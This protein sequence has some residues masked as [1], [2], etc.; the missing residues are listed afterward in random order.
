MDQGPNAE[1]GGKDDLFGSGI[2]LSERLAHFG[3]NDPPQMR[4]VSD[5][6]KRVALKF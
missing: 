4:L 1:R 2:W 5:T 6:L 3:K